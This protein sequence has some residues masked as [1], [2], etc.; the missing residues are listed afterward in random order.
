V[1]HFY[2]QVKRDIREPLIYAGILA[3]LLGYRWLKARQ[4][5]AAALPTST[6][7]SATAPERT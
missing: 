4:R 6:S 7:G 5:K 1:W 2:W 3:L